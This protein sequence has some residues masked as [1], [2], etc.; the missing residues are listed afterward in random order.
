VA[1]SN[2]N[3]ELAWDFLEDSNSH[4]KLKQ[5]SANH[6]NRQLESSE[7]LSSKEPVCSAKPNSHNS[8]LE[9]YLE[10]TP[11]LQVLVSSETQAQTLIL[12]S[13]ANSNRSSSKAPLEQIHRLLEQLLLLDNRN[14]H[15]NKP[16]L[17]CSVANSSNSL[18]QEASSTLSLP[19]PLH[20]NNSRQGCSS[21]H[22]NRQAAETCSGIQLSILPVRVAI[23]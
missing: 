3:K 23:N 11:K 4:S 6:N 1:N 9:T 19:L 17:I 7:V 21:S 2:S 15:S 14:S 12:P 22:H 16:A 10:G 13:S 8:K 18:M 20:P 5:V